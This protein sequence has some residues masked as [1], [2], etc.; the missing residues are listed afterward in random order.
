MPCT[1]SVIRKACAVVGVCP[2]G[3]DPVSGN[4]FLG[5]R[6][7]RTPVLFHFFVFF[8]FFKATPEP[9]EKFGEPPREAPRRSQN[10]ARM[11]PTN[12]FFGGSSGTPRSA[13]ILYFFNKFVD[14]M[15]SPG[16]WAFLRQSPDFLFFGGSILNHPEIALG[17]SLGRS[18]A[19]KSRFWE[20]PFRTPEHP[21]F[22]FFL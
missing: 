19:K 16:I 18:G 20:H 6:N 22:L 1:T 11:D 14:K 12:L 7:A 13:Q 10:E 3:H 9:R 2:A 15:P 17:R 4:L 8:V 21:I 5:P